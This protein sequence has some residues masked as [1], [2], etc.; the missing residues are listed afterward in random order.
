MAKIFVKL[1]PESAGRGEVFIERHSAHAAVNEDWGMFGQ[2]YIGAKD[3]FVAVADTPGVKFHLG[4]GRLVQAEEPEPGDPAVDGPEA[5]PKKPAPKSKRS[6][7]S[8]S[9]KAD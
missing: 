7:R 6:V 2:V 4:V 9:T 8:K 3:G 5:E 1:S